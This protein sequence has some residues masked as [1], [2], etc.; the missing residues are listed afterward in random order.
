MRKLPLRVSSGVA[1]IVVLW[2]VS[3]ISAAMLGLAA[4]LQG[5]LGQEIVS[6]Q[7]A[8]A[9]LVA[10]SG[11][12]M[13]LNSQVAPAEIKQAST[14]LN[15]RLSDGWKIPVH[16][17]VGD[18]Q[19]EEGK[20]NIN[21]LLLGDK[22]RAQR[23][24]QNLF[25]A[26]GVNLSTSTRLIDSLVDWV[27]SDSLTQPQ[28]AEEEDYT[29]RKRMGPRNGPF[30]SIDE[31]KKVI[32]WEEMAKEA[33]LGPQGVVNPL[34]KFTIYGSGKLSLLTA[35]QDVIEMVLDLQPGAA[36]NFMQV[37][38]GADQ[39]AGTPDDL[40]NTGLLPGANPAVLA[41]RTTN[42]GGDLWRVTSTGY[43]GEAKRT[44]VAL[45]S[46]NPP[47]IKSRWTEEED[48]P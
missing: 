2:A 13:A 15:Q 4:I 18:L 32:G 21:A 14:Q 28:G 3:L 45:I 9:G 36:T 26:W 48:Q 5:Q 44:V 23:V 1:L 35:D 34:K 30:E 46:R 8:R 42:G 25:A 16:F 20:L 24:L 10:E 33:A 22:A 41:E 11:I 17:E 29:K 7:S 6:L 27:D 12:Q 40:V 19:G 38:N 43:V 37:R 39:Q 31:L 47:Q